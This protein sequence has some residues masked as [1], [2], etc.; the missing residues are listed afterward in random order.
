[1]SL[2]RYS[3]R[4]ED[5]LIALYAEDEYSLA[6][7][8]QITGVNGSTVHKML[9]RRGVPR[10]PVGHPAKTLPA[11]ELTR[12]VWL[13]QQG[14][15]YAQ[16]AELLDVSEGAVKH[17]LAV[18]RARLNYRERRRRIRRGRFSPQATIPVH[19]RRTVESWA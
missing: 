8:E 17:R 12:T 1:M 16:V 2:P 10:R 18:A 14:L 9:I 19:V 13:R 6:E 4:H 3:R 7:V 5:E 11:E 15:T